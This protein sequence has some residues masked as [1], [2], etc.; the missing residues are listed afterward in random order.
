[1]R[2]SKKGWAII[3]VLVVAVAGLVLA[4][5]LRPEREHK[6]ADGSVLRLEKVSFGTGGSFRLGG[7]PMRLKELLAPYMSKKW[8]AAILPTLSTNKTSW[9]SILSPAHTNLPALQV[10]VSRF[11]PA[12]KHFQDV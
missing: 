1:M 2:I 3:A 9:S 4:G 6:L 7:W 12:T 10:W 8:A 5:L 11:N